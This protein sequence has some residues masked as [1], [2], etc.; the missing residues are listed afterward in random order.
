VAI[1]DLDSDSTTIINTEEDADV[2]NLEWR[3]D[4]KTLIYVSK[5]TTLVPMEFK[6][7]SFDLTHQQS[8]RIPVNILGNPAYPSDLNMALCGKQLFYSRQSNDEPFDTLYSVSIDPPG[9]STPLSSAQN[10]YVGTCSP[11]Y[12][13]NIDAAAEVCKPF[14]TPVAKIY[15]DPVTLIGPRTDVT[16]LDLNGGGSTNG[17]RIYKA[18]GC[19]GCHTPGIVAPAT[20]GMYTRIV[21]ERM[22]DPALAKMTVE[23]YLAQSVIQPIAYVVPGFNPIQP[24]DYG[25]KLNLDELRNLV[26]YMMT[27]K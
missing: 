5:N 25:Y 13:W 17:E 4:S 24:P 21:T 23:Q 1:Y 9:T 12:S 7:W 26:A 14:C 15:V 19:A 22:K 3:E 20:T 16:K 2:K 8:D 18:A 10:I 27:L 11:P 6:I